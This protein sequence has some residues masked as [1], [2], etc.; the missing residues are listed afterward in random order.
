MGTE[1]AGLSGEE[2][3]YVRGMSKDEERILASRF[4]MGGRLG[5]S[6]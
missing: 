6:N 2:D 3:E 5:I 4:S 1:E